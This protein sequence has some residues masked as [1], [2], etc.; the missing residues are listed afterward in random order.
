MKA[1]SP[2]RL[3]SFRQLFAD[4]AAAIRSIGAEALGSLVS[5]QGNPCSVEFQE[6]L[7]YWAMHNLPA[8]EAT[9]HFLICGTT[10]SGKTTAIRLFLQ[11][12]APRFLATRKTPEQL[13]LFDAK[14]DLIPQLAALGLRPDQEGVWILNPI[15]QRGA[16]WNLGEAAQT[17][18]LARHIATLFVPPES[19]SSAPYF[20]DAAR[21]LVFAVILGLNR[22]LASTWSLRDLLCALDS[23]EHIKD[24]S[25]HHPRATRIA[26]A[27]Y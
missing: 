4:T 14:C 10:G 8:T 23:L 12:I 2:G 26:Q 17:P 27:I 21:Q 20:A 22:I 24:I 7:I 3:Q 1:S 11:S 5:A 19:R 13:V 6:E 18:M 15:D 9:K 25:A 16:V